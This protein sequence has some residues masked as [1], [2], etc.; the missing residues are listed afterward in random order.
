MKKL[1]ATLTFMVALSFATQAQN[2]AF[3][4]A[5][6]KA[7]NSYQQ[8]ENMADYQQT[9][10]QFKR[11]AEMNPDE[12]LPQYNLGLTYV[13]MSFEKG[14]DGDR[15][16]ELLAVAA[17]Y[18]EQ[19][20]TLSP[21]NVEIV[22]LKGYVKMAK[23]SVNPALRGM[24]MTPQVNSLFEKALAMDPNNP[25]ALIMFARMKYGTAQFFRSSTD[26]A[27]QMARKS[28]EQFERES[29]GGIYPHWGANQARGVIKACDANG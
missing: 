18:T 10:N 3:I 4:S 23:L 24:Y 25:R 11:I 17:E 29:E 9:A 28:L 13:Y 26:D 7:V 27:C 1:I 8:I 14:L 15:R 2:N 20:E 21:E 22:V 19:A 6:E 16:D 5:M 12:W